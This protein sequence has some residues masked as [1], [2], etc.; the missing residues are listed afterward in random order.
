MNLSLTKD[1]ARSAASPAVA[2]R[3]RRGLARLAEGV[4]ALARAIAEYPARQRAYDELSRL[5]DRE[6]RDIGLSRSDIARVFDPDFPAGLTAGA[7]GAPAL[8]A[9]GGGEAFRAP[10]AAGRAG[11][12]EPLSGAA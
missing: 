3:A 11:I 6:L 4:A 1:E 8:R 5:S 7:P 12:A 10:Q 9:P 2:G